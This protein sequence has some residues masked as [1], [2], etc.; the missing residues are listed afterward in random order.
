MIGTKRKRG[1]CR[2]DWEGHH[3]AIYDVMKTYISKH[4]RAP[5][6]VEIAHITGFPLHIIMKHMGEFDIGQ[7]I[8]TSKTTVNFYGSVTVHIHQTDTL[9]EEALSNLERA[10][11]EV[12]DLNAAIDTERATAQADKAAAKADHDALMQQIADLKQQQADGASS[13]ELEQLINE[14][15]FA[16]AKLKP[17]D[18]GVPADGGSESSF[19]APGA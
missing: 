2:S 10:E 13:E 19:I 18:D 3:M 16:A 6:M 8:S 7:S 17:S 5:T 15:H 9:L 14:I 1:N 4:Q 11:Q 12:T